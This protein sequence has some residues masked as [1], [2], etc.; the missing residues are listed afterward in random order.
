MGGLVESG[1][2]W[3]FLHESAFRRFF[4]VAHG[5]SEIR[6]LEF[7]PDGLS[8]VQDRAVCLTADTQEGSQYNL[9]GVAP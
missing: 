7:D 4:A 9:A 6:F 5:L 2:Q 1:E 8:A 3:H